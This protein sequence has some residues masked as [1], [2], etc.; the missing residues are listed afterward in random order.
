MAIRQDRHQRSF[1]DA[2]TLVRNSRES[3]TIYYSQNGTRAV[4]E[5]TELHEGT[6]FI[7]GRRLTASDLPQDERNPDLLES[8]HI[9]V[10]Y[11]TSAARVFQ[12]NGIDITTGW[13]IRP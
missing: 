2:L 1:T 5:V 7:N 12:H 13:D 4:Y 3:E 10:R 8:E 6:L 11:S 9:T